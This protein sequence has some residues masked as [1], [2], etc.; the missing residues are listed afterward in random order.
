MACHRCRV[1]LPIPLVLCLLFPL[2]A[3]RR[4]GSDPQRTQPKKSLERPPSVTPEQWTTD[5]AAKLPVEASLVRQTRH[6]YQEL[7]EPKTTVLYKL[8]LSLKNKSEYTVAATTS[9]FLIETSSRD[10]SARPGPVLQASGGRSSETPTPDYSGCMEILPR[11]EENEIVTALSMDDAWDGLRLRNVQTRSRNGG[12]VRLL[13]LHLKREDGLPGATWSTTYGSAGPGQAITVGTELELWVVVTPAR[14]DQVVV[15]SPIISITADA[16]QSAEFRYLLTFSKPAGL[17]GAWQ[18][19]ERRL[20]A[21][22]DEGLTPLIGEGPEWRRLAACVWAAKYGRRGAVAALARAAGS[23]AE[24]DAMRSAALAVLQQLKSKEGLALAQSMASSTAA[25][26]DVRETATRSLGFYGD[27]SSVPLLESL[28]GAKEE[29]IASGAIDSLGLLKDERSVQAL[30][31]LLRNAGRSRDHPAAWRALQK[32]VRPA[33]LPA[34]LAL[35]GRSAASPAPEAVSAIGGI[36]SPEALKALQDFA[37]SG[38]P[39]LRAAACAGLGKL[40][41]PQALE[42]LETLAADP[43]ADVREAAISAIFDTKPQRQR[44]ELVHRVAASRHPEVLTEIVNRGSYSKDVVPDIVALLARKDVAAEVRA[45]AAEE[46][47]TALPS[48]ALEGLLS[49]LKDGSAEVRAAAAAAI[50]GF[51]DP[52]V[53][54]ALVPLLIDPNGWVQGGAATGLGRTRNPRALEP[55]LRH[56]RANGFPAEAVKAIGLLND[57]RAVEPLVTWLLGDSAS[58]AQTAEGL[59]RLTGEGFGK[60]EA[61]WARWWKENK[62]RFAGATGAT[63]A[64]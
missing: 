53:V 41:T 47:G 6:E 4:E 26:I 14:L 54:D 21:L 7:F 33:D 23:P 2:A 8:L 15:V 46:L 11:E 24:S 61:R 36:D 40:Q 59:E 38:A 30:M 52:R 31:A 64:K 3:C 45:R 25:G 57:P 50:G 35:A 27:T 17:S 60:D 48:P 32:V 49:A 55:L 29:A 43:V 42:T 56:A 5:W 34:L 39:K 9:L 28:L 19:A 20:V 1:L 44:L 16:G 37:V 12:Y 13:A 51:R 58:T 18:L 62:A 63:P 10:P 22:T